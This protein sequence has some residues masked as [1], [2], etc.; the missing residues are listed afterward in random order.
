[1][2]TTM[3]PRAG[4]TSTAAT[5]NF[6]APEI[7]GDPFPHYEKLR[8]AG[9]VQFLAHPR[10]WIVL[11]YEDVH[12]AFSHPHLFSNH[13][14]RDV[15]P[16]LLAADPPAHTAIRRIVS[17]CFSADT[18]ERL[19]AFAEERAGS[20]LAPKMDV[21]RD[22]AVPLSE[23]V[24]ARLIGFDEATLAV[25]RVARANFSSVPTYWRALDDAA[26][27][28][29][30]F[31]RFLSDGLG[32]AEVRSVIRLLWLAATTTTESAI[33]HCVMRLLRHDDIRRTLESDPTL[34]QK[35]VEEV[36]RLHPPELMVPRVTT[37]A[38]SLGNATIPAGAEVHL[39]VAA[40]NRDPAKFANP[41]E[42]RLDRP[43]VRHFTFGF[44][45]HHCVGASVSRRTI[46]ASVRTLFAH[47]PRF[48]SASSLG[49]TVATTSMI[50]TNPIEQ[51]LI[52]T[53]SRPS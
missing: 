52:D 9:S 53:G 51:L 3:M 1:M 46:E 11:G 19:A 39:C 27:R 40:A 44:G 30:L 26:G 6:N 42:L 16:V 43:A 21:V 35:F 45:I 41:S 48:R 7:A 4:S 28:A 33:S 2:R 22:Y 13:R 37:E 29:T 15:D 32:E 25:I 47:A 36:L 14:Y 12:F 5:I 31:P 24:A 20:L 18:V 17:R 8:S 10:T 23:A 38:V 50:R 34:V 49:A